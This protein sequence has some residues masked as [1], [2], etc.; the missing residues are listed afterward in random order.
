MSQQI[1]LPSRYEDLDEAYRGRLVPNTVLLTL[2]NQASKSM[3]ISG[4]IRFLPVYGESGAGKTSAVRE[5]STHIPGTYT[6]LLQREEIENKDMLL[7][8]I[9]IEK[10]YNLDKMLIAVID[11]Y[12]EG[13]VGRE[14]IPTQFVEYLSLLDRGEFRTIPIVFIW[15]TTN[16]DFLELLVRATSRN[17][18]ILLNNNFTIEGPKKEEW[19]L[20]I[21]ETFSFHNSQKTLADFGVLDD[22]LRN[23]SIEFNTI[24]AAIEHIG[25]KLASNLEDID[26][27]SE[28]QIV[29]MWPVADSTRSQR[30]LQFCKPR[31]GYKLNWEAW[32]REL[33]EDDRAQ[34]PL[35]EFNRAR[36]YFDLRV[37]PVRVADLHRLCVNLENDS[38]I[39]P[40]SSL[41]RFK[42]THF[43]LVISDSWETYNFS[44]LRE[45]ESQRATDA[46][47][48][49]ASVT[50]NPVGL[51]K[52]IARILNECGLSATY[53]QE[54]KTE[55]STVKADVFVKKQGVQ[56]NKL[57]IELKAYSSENTKPSSIKDAIKVTLR[58]HAQLA[59]F[60]QR[61]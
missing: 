23:A 30:V 25:Y 58:R 49:Y 50:E 29:L 44:P 56:K 11:Q 59:G 26:N 27:L 46:R 14:T 34:L 55:F 48:W 31:E 45:R 8:R 37:I 6:F 36:L 54:I 1:S 52:R 21:E 42:E 18:R 5:V 24:G 53:E 35:R 16:K 57:I 22:D 43:Y 3:A 33:N 51:S 13:V 15:L 19:P 28:Y 32:C 12:E 7:E 10:L 20:I 9:K 2:I 41:T 40:M 47:I 39:L 61:Q 38:V 17:R 4:G 60:L